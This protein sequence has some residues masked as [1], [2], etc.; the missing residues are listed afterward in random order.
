MD[1]WMGGWVDRPL[2]A[3]CQICLKNKMNYL[4]VE[5]LIVESLGKV[6]RDLKRTWPGCQSEDCGTQTT[7]FHEVVPL[8]R[9][10]F[11]HLNLITSP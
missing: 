8:D 10:S 2:P 3:S 6:R 1:G 11:T 9:K 7:S 5:V 4:T